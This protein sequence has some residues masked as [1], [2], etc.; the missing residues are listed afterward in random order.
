[1]RFYKQQHKFYCGA[2]L[3]TKQMYCCIVDSKGT[4]HSHTNIPTEPERFLTV[5]NP[6]RDDLVVAAK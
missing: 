2:D 5:V 6:Y 1:M 4:T 3:H